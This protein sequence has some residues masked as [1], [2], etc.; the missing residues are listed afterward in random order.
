MVCEV[1]CPPSGPVAVSVIRWRPTE[2]YAVEIRRPVPIFPARFEVHT[3]S[4]ESM[5]PVSVENALPSRSERLRRSSSPLVHRNNI[6]ID[7]DSL[8]R[9]NRELL[10]AC[11][12]GACAFAPAPSEHNRLVAAQRDSF[13]SRAQP[14]ARFVFCPGSSMKPAALCKSTRCGQPRK[15]R[16]QSETQDR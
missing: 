10:L 8:I 7:A 3:R 11:S 15:Y 1:D 12:A 13:H 16:Q 4:A 2:S 14:H 6:H 9:H 5:L